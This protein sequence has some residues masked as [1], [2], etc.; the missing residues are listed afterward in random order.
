MTKQHNLHVGRIHA[1]WCGHCV[2]LKHE[3]KKMQNLFSH[4]IGRNLKNVHV[5]YHD[6]EDIKNDPKQSGKDYQ[7]EIDAYNEKHLPHSEA[8]LA[9]QGGFPTIFRVLDGNL[10]YFSGDRNH[11][12]IFSWMTKGL[13][14]TGGKKKKKSQ[15]KRK[16]R[17]LRKK[18][19]TRKTNFFGFF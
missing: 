4:A 12:S 11:G 19:S 18:R 16:S 1:D 15:R 2:S 17:S 7:K 14:K 3:W 5:E 10:E 9:L 8:K 13:V 6:F